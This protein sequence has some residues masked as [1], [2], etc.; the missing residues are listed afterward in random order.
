VGTGAGLSTLKRRATKVRPPR[1]PAEPA[2]PRRLF[3]ILKRLFFLGLG[4]LLLAAV[5][6]AG[7]FWYYAR[8]LPSVEELKTFRPPQGSKVT[9]RDGSVC[10]EYFVERR[11]WVELSSL[12]PHVK[13]AFLAAEDADFYKHEGLDYLGMARAFVKALLPGGRMT[14]AST[15]SQQACRNLLLTQE[16]SLSRK[17]KE[18]ILTPRMEDAL[19][20]DEILA[21][22]MNFV[23]FGN[24]R[25]GIEEAALFYFGKHAKDLSLGEA[26]VLA[27]TVQSPA[28]INPLTNIVKSKRRQ[29]YVLNQL[30]RHKFVEQKLID[31]EVD[32]PIVLGPRP[33]AQVGQYYL[34]DVRKVLAQRYGDKKLL[35][36]GLRV[37]IAMDPALQ[38][39]AE[40][41]LRDALEALDRRQGYRGHVGTL[42]P[43]RWAALR[44]F[45]ETRLAE[46]GKRRPEDVLVADLTALK[47]LKPL[48]EEGP[49][50]EP[51]PEGVEG[52]EE[53]PPSA[54][55]VL[56]RGVGVHALSEGLAT[57]GYV[58]AVDDARGV[59]TLDVVGKSAQ[60]L[61]STV[62]WA[63]PRNEK[64]QLGTPP[65]K[66]SD[67]VQPGALVRVKL[68]KAIAASRDVEATLAQVPAAEGA[69]VAID[70]ADRTVVALVGGYD[71]SRSVFN[72][73]TQA[74]RQPGSSFK[75]FIYGAALESEKYTTVSIVND[76]PE[77]IRDPYT[78]KLWKPQNYEKGGFDGPVTLRQALTHSK[79]TVSV[80]LI[81]ALTPTTV[82][83][84]A[85]KAGIHS[86]MPDNLTLALGTGEVTP[87]EIANAYATLQSLGK[88]AEPVMLIK[89]SDS[90]GTVLEEHHAALEEGL[91]PPIA[92]LTTSLMRSVVEEG[93][94]MAVRELDR[95]A[96]GKTGTAQEFRDAW[97]SGYTMEWVATAWV[98]FDDHSPLGPSE[99]GGKAAL[100]MWLNFMK[101]AHQ[102]KPARDFE[103]PAGIA[104]V[105]IDPVTRLL[106]GKSVPGRLEHFLEGTQPTTLA[107]EPGSVD[108]NDF[109]LQ[110]GRRR[111]L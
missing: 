27:G 83:A 104:S 55:E 45:I 61:F 60:L 108:P 42:P 105:R 110:D 48:P 78:G 37:Q 76:A 44:P 97:F 32:K 67:V 19:S 54:D 109:L 91:S 25:Y 33:P 79:N 56:A 5:G 74:K 62:G 49:D 77:A 64:G 63:R 47:D 65:Q 8:E 66:L 46:A 14:G 35:E 72:R 26:A 96:A 73:A 2:K 23:W 101:A 17:I 20:K 69:L 11:T 70:P 68:G 51:S 57:V 43:E 15:I 6:T 53:A 103:A 86:A 107:P 24:Q 31:A 21:L 106:A 3:R 41:S 50:L 7:A 12:P 84:F 9:C 18:W 59:A 38:A 29:K 4:A 92:Y 1:M 36:G 30:S 98:G 39:A 10:G 85:E 13:N 34:E 52:S 87:L 93:T 88:T 22:Y 100:P 71:F 58:S 95:P 111:G 80:R 16:R 75:P 90:S 82:K 94:A 81:E 89:V 102:G 99:T 40:K 28:R